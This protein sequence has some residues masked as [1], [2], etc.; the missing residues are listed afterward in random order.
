WVRARSAALGLY[1]VLQPADLGGGGV[2]ALGMVALH[3]AVGRSG[4]VLGHLALGGDGGLL[5]FSS[6]A[7]R[8]RFL[9]PVLRGEAAAA[10]ACGAAGWA[11]AHALD[12]ARR[13]HRTGAPLGEREQ[14][15]AMLGESAT[16]LYAARAAVYATA[17]R[18]EACEDIETEAAMAKATATEMAAR[19]VDRA[20]QLSGAAA[21]VEDHPLARLYRRIR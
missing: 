20:I 14:V 6:G 12:G 21:V 13:P 15:Q 11:L 7:Q 5:R 10:L 8:E 19:V 4:C 17:A 1:R 16:E 3:E 2:G 18:A 9:G